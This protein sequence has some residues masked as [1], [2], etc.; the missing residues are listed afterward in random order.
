MDIFV[1]NIKN[2]TST[3][4]PYY[5]ILININTRYAQIHH[6]QKRSSRSILN[7]LKYIFHKLTIKS[8]E[9]DE[10]KSFVSS[11]I[12]TYLKK[13]KV[14]YYVITEQQYQ[15]LAI[16][17]CFIRT[18]RDYLKKNESGDNSKITRFV[19]AY[20]N[21]IYNETELSPKQMQ[22]DKQ[23]EVNYVITK[24]SEH[25]NVENQP[26]YKVDISDKVRLIE[27]KHTMKKTRYNITPYYFVISGINGKSI[28][29]SAADGSVKT[30]TRPRIISLKS[31]EISLKQAKTIP[32]TSLGSVT[33]ILNYNPKK[34]TCKN[35]FEIEGDDYYI[36]NISSKELRVN[37]P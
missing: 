15:S 30:V 9:S 7:A 1:N 10:E 25:A 28:I 18:M 31:N 13:H 19:N 5:L 4:Y 12:L 32:G 24:L 36:D 20:N 33:K 37:K 6:L 2:N 34:D 35:R 27:S 16:I 8:F 17:D 21:T 3:I 14:D 11:I 26:G 23:L 29:I 22:N